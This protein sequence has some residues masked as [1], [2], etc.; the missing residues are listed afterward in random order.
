MGTSQ[1]QAGKVN[2]KANTQFN[3]TISRL[4]PESAYDV[5][6]LAQDSANNYSQVIGMYTAH[7]LDETP[8]SASL[9][10]ESY[11]AESP[12]TPYAY[13]T[14][15][16]VFSEA[17]RYRQPANAPVIYSELRLIELY[18]KYRTA[19]PA[20]KAKAEEEY[21][22]ALRDTIILCDS[23]GQAVPVRDWDQQ[24][25][26]TDWVVDYRNVQVLQDGK[27]MVV[28]FVNDPS[29]PSKS[30]LNLESGA[31]YFFHLQ[32]ITD[33]SQSR[34]QMGE[35]DMDAFTT[36]SARVGI[37]KLDDLD[38]NAFKIGRDENGNPITSDEPVYVYNDIN[39]KRDGTDKISADIAFT[40]DPRSTGTAANGVKWDM[41]FW[42]D[43]DVEFMLF[44]RIHGDENSKWVPVGVDE[45]GDP[46]ILK[47]TVPATAKNYAGVSVIKNLTSNG[48]SVSIPQYHDINEPYTLGML[49]GGLNDAT[50]NQYDFALYFTKVGDRTDRSS[51]DQLINGQV[52]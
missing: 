17:I 41:I 14:I 43:R 35:Q 36:V 25:D 27:N 40:A 39:N 6:Y 42:F 20:D 18:N 52:T 38:L 50:E 49:D 48:T 16:V 9:R 12:E 44:T 47:I 21:V 13:S 28:S 23:S 45:N 11:P 1:S 24:S 31:Q 8:P 46:G 22:G 4:Q 51:F 37:S 3:I 15:D 32:N 34:N 19:A 30:A 10:F 5:Y 33:D 26:R 29:E 7:T 2:A